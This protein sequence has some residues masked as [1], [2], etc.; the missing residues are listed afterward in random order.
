MSEPLATLF[1]EA[2]E[3]VEFEVETTK[4]EFTET[5]LAAMETKGITKAK[6]A[7]LLGVKPAR[8][9]A[10]LRGDNNF[11]IDT[12][13]RLC[14]ALGLRFMPGFQERQAPSIT[15]TAPKEHAAHRPKIKRKAARVARAKAPV[16]GH[17]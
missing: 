10:L 3:T 11:T 8:V 1:R 14:R 15:F 13:V 4:L 16:L 5:L 6:L 17:A 7:E 9:S 2:S 12:M